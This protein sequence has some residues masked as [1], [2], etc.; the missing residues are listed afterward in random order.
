MSAGHG[1]KGEDTMGLE[2]LLA[3]P[4]VPAR[5]FAGWGDASHLQ[6]EEPGE[7]RPDSPFGSEREYRFCREVADHPFEPSSAYPKRAGM[8]AKTAQA[9]R[10]SLVE[11]G[12]IREHTLD[13]KGRG[14]S[15]I[16]LEAL[17]AGKAAVVQHESGEK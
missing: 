3:L 16:V 5:E 10:Q 11:K 9:V 8:S 7:P 4:A 17:P 12:Y 1:R 14:R 15:A 2:A 6:P 13:T